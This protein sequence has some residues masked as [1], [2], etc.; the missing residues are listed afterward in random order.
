ME[1][2][3]DR[4]QP[5]TK[6]S[7]ERIR[8]MVEALAWVERRGVEGDMVECGVWRGG[9][10]ILARLLAP[11]R[12]C[13]LYDTFTGMTMP[14]DRDTK[15]SGRRAIEIWESK[16]NWAAVSADEVRAN[17]REWG[18]SDSDKLRFVEGPVEETLMLADNLPGRVALLRLDTDWYESTKVELE[19]LYPRLASGG[20]LI[21]DDYGHWEGARQAVNEYLGDGVSRLMP[22]DYTAVQ[23]VKP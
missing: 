2:L 15:R 13:W 11:G 8:S 1:E 5:Y 18:L 4:V 19:V 6:S 7:R 14:T 16:P 12:Q 9:N 17:F 20:I 3:I 22:I 21:V 10:I 23:M